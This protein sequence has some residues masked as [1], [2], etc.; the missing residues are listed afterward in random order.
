LDA[1]DTSLSRR[2]VVRALATAL[3]SL[4]TLSGARVL[5]QPPPGPTPAPMMQMPGKN[6]ARTSLHQEVDFQA[7]PQRV[8]AALLSAKAFT[9]FTGHEATV[10]AKPGSAFSLFGGLITGRNVELVPN[11]EIVQAWRATSWGPGIYSIVRFDL[12]PTDAGTHLAL[13]QTAFPDGE[14]EHLDAGWP[15][16]YWKPLADYL[17]SGAG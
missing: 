16:N 15:V 17:G 9:A 10:D 13:T 2:F 12:T 11:H 1:I 3:G 8:Y 6:Q 4:A 14:Y 7:S 5:A